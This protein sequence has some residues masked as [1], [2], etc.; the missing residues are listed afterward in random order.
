LSAR[1]RLASLACAKLIPAGGERALVV[2]GAKGFDST[3]SKLSDAVREI[4][5]MADVR[6]PAQYVMVAV[7]GIGWKSRRSDLRRIYDMWET[8]AINGM[9]TLRSLD[10]LAEDLGDAAR[11]LGLL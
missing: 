5:E 6:L 10:A 11:R 4:E 8:N 2:I 9:Y 1:G 3:G 7:D